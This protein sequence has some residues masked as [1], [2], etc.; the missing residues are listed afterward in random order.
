[1]PMP[2]SVL[3]V[4]FCACF[5]TV[6]VCADRAMSIKGFHIGMTRDEYEQQI[7]RYS[8][9]GNDLRTTKTPGAPPFTL[10]GVTIPDTPE[11]GTYSSRPDTSLGSHIDFRIP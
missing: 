6:V 4:V 1:M 5:S 7:N 10:A 11:W 2:K 3:F 8:W 9:S